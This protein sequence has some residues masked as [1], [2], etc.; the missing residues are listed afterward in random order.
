MMPFPHI[1]SLFVNW[2]YMELLNS[3]RCQSHGRVIEMDLDS[4]LHILKQ[5]NISCVAPQ[6]V[7][8]WSVALGQYCTSDC[9]DLK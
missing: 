5:S 9:K 2:V 8:S 4:K 6:A 1:V 3:S 7:D